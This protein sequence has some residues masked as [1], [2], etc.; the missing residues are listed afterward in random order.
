M[1]NNR[2]KVLKS[3]AA[4]PF[5]GSM[6]RVQGSALPES[7]TSIE[8]LGATVTRDYFKELGLRTFINAAGT[9]TS[10]TGCLMP[11]EVSDA[12]V[13]G[14]SDYVNL[15]D[16]QDKVGERIA[17]LVECEY[18][19]VTSGCFGA[20]SIAMAGVLCGNDA[21]KV[22]QLPNTE[23]WANEVIIQEGHQIG[24]SQA[25]TNVGAKIITVKTAK[26]MKAAISDRT[27]MLWYLNANTENGEVKWEEFLAIAKKYNIPTMIDCAADV[28]PVENLFRFTKM[29]FDMVTFS[30][31]KGLRGPQSAGL[32]LG[33]RKYVEAARMHTPPRGETIGRGM[34]VNKEEVLGMLVALE[35]YL[36]KDHDAEWKMWEY[37]IQ[38]I[39]DAALSV[40]G[41]ETEIHVPPHA[42]HVPSLRISWNEKKVKISPPDFRK[43]L[44]EGHPSIQTVGGSDSVGITTWMMQPGQER[45]VAKRVKEI[46][47]KYA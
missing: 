20:M 24:Y 21:S 32:L 43:E 23:G 4:L 15:D 47:T 42:N 3:L 13:Y 38:L 31:G 45:I 28:P 37:Q 11:K 25:L 35:L 9:Y 26:E 2:R 41:V 1:K 10:M 27:A 29:G 40:N 18:A 22:K 14:T 19:T 8:T 6:W 44:M 17:E 34:K 33:K 7:L 36:G 30:G 16:L 12:I 39:S 5:L 46:L